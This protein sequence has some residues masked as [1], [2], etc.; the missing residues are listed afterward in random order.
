[1]TK[2]IIR[3]GDIF[4]IDFDKNRKDIDKCRA[5]LICSNDLLNEYSESVMVAPITSNLHKIYSF[6][7]IIN[8]DDMDGKIM[9]DQIRSISKSRILNKIHSLS[10]QNMKQVDIIIRQILG[11]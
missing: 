10:D 1:M 11:I 4:Y 8:C 7:Y 9:F 2:T 5:A 3:R 6:E